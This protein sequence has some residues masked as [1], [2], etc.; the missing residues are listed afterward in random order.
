MARSK[1]GWRIG[2]AVTVAIALIAVAVASA[3]PDRSNAGAPFKVMIM[4][5]FNTAINSN[6]WMV[7]S[8]QAAVNVINAA[9]GLKGRPIVLSSCN[10]LGN[11]TGQAA[12]ARQAVAQ[13]IDDV[14]ALAQFTAG[15]NP[16]LAA[17]KIPNIGS[18]INNPID[19][20]DRYYV[21]ILAG[22]A[23]FNACVPFVLKQLGVHK[24]AILV[25]DNA[26]AFYLAGMIK[27][28]AKAAGLKVTKTIVTP[29]SAADYA[30]YVQAAKQ[31]G[32][33]GIAGQ[34]TA[35][36]NM[37]ILRSQA[38]L[39][40]QVPLVAQNSNS[41]DSILQQFGN[42]GNGL[43]GCNQVPSLT[44]KSNAVVAR[45]NAEMDKVGV[46]SERTQASA[47][48]AWISMYGLQALAQR[49]KGAVTSASLLATAR[50]IKKVNPIK[51]FGSLRWTPGVKGPAAFPN[52]PNGT[53]FVQVA[54]NG[55][56][57][58]ATDVKPS[59]FDVWQRLHIAR[60]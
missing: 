56:W 7:P 36:G 5:G 47:F 39:G 17:A 40:W 10:T 12:C 52:S 42:L 21:P 27:A 48:Q 44:D 37:G 14:Q 35:V 2:I 26:T 6:P 50:T 41:N 46:G 34:Q 31:S 60:S 54:K 11:A 13:K 49:T 57:I 8:A 20:N 4:T 32:A 9:G 23:Q 29:L 18:S 19:Y 33:D 22:A 1:L 55:H 28:G 16:I 24:F 43:H 45:Y 58:N 30:P 59:S 25:V 53:V 3:A 38:Q 15:S 51:L